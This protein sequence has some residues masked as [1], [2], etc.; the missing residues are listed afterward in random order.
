MSSLNQICIRHRFIYDAFLFLNYSIM[1]L[2]HILNDSSAAWVSSE[3]IIT[4]RDK[5]KWVML[6]H[7]R[8]IYHGDYLKTIEWWLEVNLWQWER[9]SEYVLNLR[10]DNIVLNWD[11]LTITDEVWGSK[12]LLQVIDTDFTD[13]TRFTLWQ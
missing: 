8:S 4:E 1:L 7:I 3:V 13:E 2:V 5:I 9:D 10:W 12:R 11:W 6:D